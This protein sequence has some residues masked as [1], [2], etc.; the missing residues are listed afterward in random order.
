MNGAKEDAVKNT[1]LQKGYRFG[2]FCLS[3]STET[4][5]YKEEEIRLEP[6]VFAVLKYLCE[7]ND[8]YTSIQELHENV[9]QNRV[10]TD[11][12]VRRSLTKLRNILSKNA[13]G[14]HFIKSIHK[15]GY[16]LD[17]EVRIV[18][19]I[20]SPRRRNE[21][22][23]SGGGMFSE[24]K[25]KVLTSPVFVVAFLFVISVAAAFWIYER[26]VTEIVSSD[27]SIINYPGEKSDVVLSTDERYLA[28]AGKA[29]SYLGHQLFVK[30]MQ[31]S[32]IKQL[33]FNEKNIVKVDFAHDQ[34][35]LLYI[36]MTPGQSK[37]KKVPLNMR[38]ASHIPE[39]L[40]DDFYII[41]DFVVMPKGTGIVFNGMKE[42]T[43]TSDTFFFDAV[44]KEITYFLSAIEGENYD[45]KV[46]L[47]KQGDYLAVTTSLNNS[48][49]QLITVY[50]TSTK[51]VVNR[52]YHDKFLFDIGWLH[53]DAILILD[54]DNFSVIDTNTAA[55]EVLKTNPRKQMRS[56]YITGNTDQII[57]LRDMDEGSYFLELQN[58]PFDLT[59]NKVMEPSD[60]TLQR[61]FFYDRQNTKLYVRHMDGISRLTL[62]KEGASEE[63]EILKVASSL[64]VLDVAHVNKKILLNMD[65]RKVIFD[66]DSNTLNY[67]D[68]N[69]FA[70]LNNIKFTLDS[71]FVLYG[72]KEKQQWNIHKYDI[73]SGRS[74][75]LIDGFKS[76]QEYSSGYV[77]QNEAGEFFLSDF[78]FNVIEQIENAA[79]ED[80]DSAWITRNDSLFWSEFN[81]NTVSFTSIDLSSNKKQINQLDGTH[82]NLNFDVDYLG[83]KVLLNRKKYPT[84]KV[85]QFRIS[86]SI[87]ASIQ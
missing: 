42:R 51:K 47:S 20:K 66:V 5:F 36:D 8:H 70:S 21:L 79:V 9:W 71:N 29:F 3:L 26:P 55:K 58:N 10:V 38:S 76:A 63:E 28:F 64:D 22:R 83:Q 68:V 61:V 43:D 41:S 2:D 45:Y 23:N 59:N 33:T 86:R 65:E 14:R 32:N 49:E 12:A 56:F 82:F 75:F 44:T 80:F 7:N 37:L 67:L 48:E 72:L 13:N 77:L 16:I 17:E 60:E 31:T 52:F 74:D 19:D 27:T 54:Q 1:N 62:K 35:H 78:E 11:A 57:A 15:R 73:S 84:T 39:T 6:Q 24:I 81:G 40:V 30:D 50:D 18:S 53:D 4:L 25:N 69:K 87:N 34:Q 46:A 85:S